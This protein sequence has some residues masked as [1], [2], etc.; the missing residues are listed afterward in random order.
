MFDLHHI[1]YGLLFIVIG[2]VS[3]K[4]NYQLVGFTGHP[5]WIESKL[6]SGSTYAVYKMLS[7]LIILGAI[8]YMIGAGDAVMNWLLSPIA[9]FFHGGGS[10][11]TTTP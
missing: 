2:V 1:F 8:I 10:G 5:E 4:Y 9:G 6:G 11:P 7:V 3:L